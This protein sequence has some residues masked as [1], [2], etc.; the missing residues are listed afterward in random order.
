M[1]VNHNN[2]YYI[3]MMRTILRCESATAFD[4]LS[5]RMQECFQVS[6]SD[7]RLDRMTGSYV[8]D[9]TPWDDIVAAINDVDSSSK[10]G[11]PTQY[12]LQIVVEIS[13]NT[14]IL[15]KLFYVPLIRMIFV[16][17]F[18]LFNRIS[19]FISN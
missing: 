12:S 7:W 16:S 17:I 1:L 4:I 2:I 10:D 18:K 6:H 19:F 9:S 11:G 3:I 13:R 5:L 14:K 8:E 15:E